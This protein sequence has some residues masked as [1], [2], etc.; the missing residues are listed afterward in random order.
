MCKGHKV[1]EDNFHTGFQDL[2]WGCND[3]L[4]QI[5]QLKKRSRRAWT[6]IE[7]NSLEH[8]VSALA[9]GAANADDIDWRVV[10]RAVP[11]RTAKQCR[12]KWLSDLRPGIDQG[13][14]ALQEEYVLALA[15]SRV[16]N[17]W[18]EIARYLPTRPINRVKNRWHSA[19]RAT[20]PHK[21]DTFLHI[22]T[23]LV[24]RDKKSEDGGCRGG[25]RKGKRAREEEEE[26]EEEEEEEEED[27]ATGGGNAAAIEAAK[28]QYALLAAK[29]LEVVPL[30]DFEVGLDY[31][32]RP[33][34]DKEQT[35][36]N[37][38]GNDNGKRHGI[39]C[40][41]RGGGRRRTLPVRTVA[42]GG[43]GGGGGNDASG[44]G[45]GGGGGGGGSGAE[46]ETWV[47]GGGE[48]EAA[49]AAA[50]KGSGARGKA[51]CK[52]SAGKTARGGSHSPRT[53]TATAN[54]LNVKAGAEP[55][56]PVHEP[57]PRA[58]KPSG[59]AL[60]T[61]GGGGGALGQRT[62]SPQH[63]APF[64]LAPYGMP[65]PLREALDAAERI[66]R[67]QGPQGP[68][69]PQRPHG[70]AC[71]GMTGQR[72]G[73]RDEQPARHGDGSDGGDG[74]NADNCGCGGGDDTDEES[75]WLRPVAGAQWSPG[76][77]GS[78]G[79]DSAFGGGAM[80]ASW[81]GGA[82]FSA[83]SFWDTREIEN[84]FA[85]ELGQPPPGHEATDPCHLA[86]QQQPLRHVIS[87]LGR[88]SVCHGGLRASPSALDT[89]EMEDYIDAQLLAPGR[90]AN[91]PCHSMPQQ[92]PPPPLRPATSAPATFALA[93]LSEPGLVP[94]QHHGLH[95]AMTAPSGMGHQAGGGGAG[96][97]AG[98]AYGAAAFASAPPQPP[99]H[100]MPPPL[101]PPV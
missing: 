65:G 99:Q 5:G 87:G 67:P 93:A 17:K 24:R 28:E 79:A 34:G 86:P 11:G 31:Y 89:N 3:S 39:P 30:A 27:G 35:T 29:S 54:A 44:G 64:A 37:G 33:G 20:E 13:A 21:V 47:A 83:P 43:G 68:Q 36:A 9:P 52:G 75:E 61:G 49:A 16:G 59:S 62:E 90:E 101:P 92:E 32:L 66:V 60:G 94:Q 18:A 8:A 57:P 97:G 26:D 76:S 38:N 71:L 4:K 84:Y 58:Y 55:A 77:E 100:M 74:R 82:F 15:H 73:E 63:P 22:Y 72:L 1:S 53:A 41:K 48:R 56:D 85:A 80:R 19:R 12:E 2:R 81:S 88:K 96:A 98:G 42:A 45:D 91:G 46:I 78:Q 51:G 7:K 69:G 50:S 6:K 23:R 95:W 10:A 14:W 70:P 25:G 40:R